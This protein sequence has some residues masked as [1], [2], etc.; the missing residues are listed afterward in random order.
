MLNIEYS[1]RSAYYNA[2]ER[3]QTKEQDRIFVQYLIKK[4]LKEYQK[5]VN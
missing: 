3:S 2:L 4:Y 1:N 5:F